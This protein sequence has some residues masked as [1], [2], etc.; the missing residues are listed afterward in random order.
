MKTYH[1][2]SFVDVADHDNRYD[3]VNIQERQV[4]MRGD[5]LHITRAVSPEKIYIDGESILDYFR[6]YIDTQIAEA[7]KKG[8]NR[9]KTRSALQANDA[10]YAGK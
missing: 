10:G 2:Y 8:K 6:G 3:T 9:T 5:E 1:H 7:L 4:F